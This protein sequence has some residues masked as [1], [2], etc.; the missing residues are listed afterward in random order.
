MGQIED[1]RP[2]T[3]KNFLDAPTALLVL[4]KGDCEPCTA[5]N[6][7]LNNQLNQITLLHGVCVGKILL[8]APGF[9]QFKLD[10]TW[11]SNVDVLPFNALFINGERVAEWAGG[12][13][14]RLMKELNGR[15]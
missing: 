15:A 6:S 4:G 5:W 12:S 7:I 9:G 2:N 1:L 3:W 13:M 14:D 10:H 11:V 8:D